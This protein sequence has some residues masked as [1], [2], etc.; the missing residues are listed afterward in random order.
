MNWG[1]FIKYTSKGSV[2][3]V[4][5]NLAGKF[6]L[7]CCRYLQCL[8]CVYLLLCCAFCDICG[9]LYRVLLNELY[10]QE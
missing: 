2:K 8:S 1:I 6:S 4:L 7:N 3:H 10:S 9:S 5:V